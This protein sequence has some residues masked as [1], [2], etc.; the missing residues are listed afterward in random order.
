V[1]SFGGG[2]SAGYRQG[3][4]VSALS[5]VVLSAGYASAASSLNVFGNSCD[6]VISGETLMMVKEHFITD[7]SERVQAAVHHGPDRASESRVPE[8][9]ARLQPAGR[10]TAAG[11]RK[12]E[13]VLG[14]IEE[15]AN[16]LQ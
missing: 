1:Y 16:G 5:D 11:Q 3:A 13:T 10:G 15:V 14:H 6:D 7:R 2:C 12:L 4:G 8:G 9:R